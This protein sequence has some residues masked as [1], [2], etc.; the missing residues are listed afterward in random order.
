MADPRA[1]TPSGSGTTSRTEMLLTALAVLV[2][3][4]SPFTI[5]LGPTAWFTALWLDVA[6]TAVAA[7]MV[8]TRRGVGC[9]EIFVPFVATIAV[10]A[11]TAARPG[12][13][14]P[15]I[16]VLQVLAVLAVV[17]GVR[18]RHR[19]GDGSK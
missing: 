15:W 16:P 7:V 3:T 10:V 6:L 17:A 4:L 12:E 11:S 5:A 14:G 9:L 1:T 8:W 13:V 18:V 19:G 2:V